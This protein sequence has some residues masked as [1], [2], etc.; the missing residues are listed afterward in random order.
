MKV[1]KASSEDLR[2]V[3]RLY[4]A[5]LDEL[6][7]KYDDNLVEKK[8]SNAY[9]CAPCFLLELDGRIAGMAGLTAGVIC[10][11]GEV[12]LSDYMVYVEPEHRSLPHLS[13]LV[14]ACKDFASEQKCSLRLDFVSENDEKLRIRLLKMHGFQVGSI[15]GVFDGRN[16]GR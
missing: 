5:G 15:V 8:V 14:N 16:N 10:Y 4:R 7:Y 3:C 1:R 11:S 6:G 2:E 9:Y 12:T 13:G